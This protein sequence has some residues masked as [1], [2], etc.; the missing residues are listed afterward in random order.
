MSGNKVNSSNIVYMHEKFEDVKNK[1]AI[2]QNC[3][4]I[5]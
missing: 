5:E 4:L 2:L 1:D 3:I